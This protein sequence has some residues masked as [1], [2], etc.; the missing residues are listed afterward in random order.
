M[1]KRNYTLF[2]EKY[3]PRILGNHY[4]MNLYGDCIYCGLLVSPSGNLAKFVTTEKTQYMAAGKVFYMQ[5]DA[6]GVREIA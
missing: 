1:M 4:K 5:Y 3:S 6:L 2:K